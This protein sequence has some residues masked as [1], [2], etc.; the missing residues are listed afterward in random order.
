MQAII[1]Y[2]RW[3][4]KKTSSY[5]LDHGAACPHTSYGVHGGAAVCYVT[6]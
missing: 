5:G 6:D 1:A 4:M 2:G 3:R